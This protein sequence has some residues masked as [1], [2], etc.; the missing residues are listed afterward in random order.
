CTERQEDKKCEH[1]WPY[2]LQ[3]HLRLRFVSS[4]L[5]FTNSRTLVSPDRTGFSRMHDPTLPFARRQV[6][7]RNGSG[8]VHH[9]NFTSVH[10]QRTRSYHSFLDGYRRAHDFAAR[11]LYYDTAPCSSATLQSKRDHRSNANFAARVLRHP[12]TRYN[13]QGGN[14]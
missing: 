1:Y 4:P 7:L 3:S 13:S 2:R 9:E 11:D 14:L 10:A 8:C 5:P 6:I 12:A